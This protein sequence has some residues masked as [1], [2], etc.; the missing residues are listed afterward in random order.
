MLNVVFLNKHNDDVD[1]F[2]D[3]NVCGC[4]SNFLKR[5]HCGGSVV[6]RLLRDETSVRTLSVR[7][8]SNKAGQRGEEPAWAGERARLSG[9]NSVDCHHISRDTRERPGR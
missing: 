4:N 8:I 3:S 6:E 9:V 1:N 2:D 7:C 5:R